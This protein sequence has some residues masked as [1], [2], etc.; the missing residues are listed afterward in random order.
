MSGVGITALLLRDGTVMKKGEVGWM[1]NCSANYLREARQMMAGKESI[2]EFLVRLFANN[3][4]IRVYNIIAFA[5]NSN[6]VSTFKLYGKEDTKVAIVGIK[7]VPSLLVIGSKTLQE[8]REA[9]SDNFRRSQVPLLFD[10]QFNS[11][12]VYL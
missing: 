1:R 7:G 6:L 8:F 12:N 11:V 4:Q 2:K 5:S 9:G 10:S 3:V